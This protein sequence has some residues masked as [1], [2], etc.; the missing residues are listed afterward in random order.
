MPDFTTPAAFTISAYSTSDEERQVVFVVPVHSG[1]GSRAWKSLAVKPIPSYTAARLTVGMVAS[2]AA[3]HMGFVGI[4]AAAV[5]HLALPTYT[6]HWVVPGTI[7]LGEELSLEELQLPLA[8][9]LATEG[10][11]IVA[12]SRRASEF[13]PPRLRGWLSKTLSEHDKYLVDGPRNSK[14]V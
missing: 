2:V 10:V 9:S 14:A 6:V 11:W 7:I 1:A 13:T 4:P 12:S 3:L 5:P 8:E